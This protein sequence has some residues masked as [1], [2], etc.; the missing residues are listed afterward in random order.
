MR[1]EWRDTTLGDLCTI[2]K[3]TS[4]TQ[5]TLPGPYPLIVT[6]P[7]PLS[8]DSFQ[9]Q[10][11]AVCVPLVSSTG[12]GHASL[13]RVHYASGKFAVAN[14]IAACVPRA[15]AGVDARFLFHYLQHFKDA[16]IV[17]RMK[18]TA[19]VSLSITNLATV[20]V[21][22]PPL[23]EQRRIVDLI[24]AV[25]DAVDAA[26]AEAAATEDTTRATALQLIEETRGDA[27]TLGDVATWRS[28]GTPP[29]SQ[30][31]F[32]ENGTVRWAN[33]RDVQNGPIAETANRVTESGAERAGGSC[34]RGTV[35]VTM[36]G[37][38]GRSALVEEPM[39]TNRAER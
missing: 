4:P 11:E 9:F 2:T 19:N 30:R 38:I 25:D 17:T 36:Y 29:V 14:I 5:K 7:E 3:G 35:L 37:S 16:E 27:L 10:G 1:D 6:G 39:A 28:G 33:I 12:H 34:A 23:D 20:P 13:K 31:E 8:S 24:A 22:L 15:G 32:Y 26:E 21:A 18:G